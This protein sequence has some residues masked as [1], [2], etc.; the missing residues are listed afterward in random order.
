[1][2][3]IR[4]IIALLA[5]LIATVALADDCAP[6][7]VAELKLEPVESG[8]PVVRVTVNG[9]ARHFLVEPGALWTAMATKTATQ[10]GLKP[11]PLGAAGRSEIYS[12]G[13]AQS[14]FA[15]PEKLEFGGLVV[16]HPKVLLLPENV[17]GPELDGVLG[18]DLLAKFDLDFD[19]GQ[20]LLRL[21]SS[22]HCPGHVADWTH[23]LV[24][25][26]FEVSASRHVVVP[27]ML[28]G[29]RVSVAIDTARI[30]TAM[31]ES[32]A[33]RLFGLSAASPGVD[34]PADADAA[35]SLKFRTQ[36][37]SLSIS[38]LTI[39]YPTV[40]VWA[41]GTE[42]GWAERD[43]D[44]GAVVPATGIQ[45][46]RQDLA[47]GTELLRHLHLYIDFADKTISLSAAD[48]H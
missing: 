48:A 29:K 8:S 9:S 17:I 32:S 38:G 31:S 11:L 16:A 3:P 5:C 22:K 18:S 28:D 36:F 33:A 37:D 20:R 7:V 45:R 19:F 44:L 42:R 15:A 14:Q 25:V 12:G 1:M 39:R 47:I 23:E 26:P 2:T 21:V 35:K 6:A 46:E 30:K 4:S 34:V 43:P 27:M 13:D 40:Y 10:L 41:D 24:S